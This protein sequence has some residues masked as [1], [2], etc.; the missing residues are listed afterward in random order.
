MSFFPA[1][2]PCRRKILMKPLLPFIVA[3]LLASASSALADNF[4][5]LPAGSLPTGWTP[6]G[7]AAWSIAQ[8]GD[9]QLYQADGPTDSSPFASTRVAEASADGSFT[10]STTFRIIGGTS[11][12]GGE[13]I[14]LV[15][16]ATQADLSA[17]SSY[18][19]ADVQRGSGVLRIVS[20]G[21]PNP[22]F[23]AEKTGSFV[24]A[25]DAQTVYTLTLFATPAKN[26]IALKLT[27]SD[28][29]KTTSVT[30]VDPTPLA[31][32]LFG[33]RLNNTTAGESL[34]VGFA[35]FDVVTAA[36]NPAK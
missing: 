15:A 31:G 2:R 1:G 21:K 19:L 28:G 25:L 30:A 32:R 11:K 22:D 5:T 7:K 18:Y 6:A 26:G 35:D 24:R 10:L 20:R 4:R 29:K 36:T 17:S 13:Y 9:T 3:A 34:K 33:L 8:D 23:V 12:P 16:C 27:L 14:G